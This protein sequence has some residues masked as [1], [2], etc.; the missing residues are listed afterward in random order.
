[1][2][3]KKSKRGSKSVLV[4]GKM[5]NITI[6]VE[7]EDAASSTSGGEIEHDVPDSSSAGGAETPQRVS[8]KETTSSTSSASP[9]WGYVLLLHTFLVVVSQVHIVFFSIFFNRSLTSPPSSTKC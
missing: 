6:V 7:H 5:S 8:G 2:A 3:Y 9:F 1:L 4:N